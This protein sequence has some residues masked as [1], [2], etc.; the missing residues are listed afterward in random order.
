[1]PVYFLHPDLYVFPHPEMADENGIL[2]IGGDLDPER[3]LTAYRF[4]IFPW[5]DEDDPITW[6]SPDPRAVVIPG[7]VKVS[8]SMRPYLRKY[9]LKID[10]SFEEVISFCKEIQRNDEFG[11]WITGEMMKT[12]IELHHLG[13]AHSFETW[14]DGKLIGGLYGLSLG[15][16]FFGESM[17]SLK[18]N[19]SKFAFIKLSQL[20]KQWEFLLIDCQVPNDHLTSM[21]CT[22]I[23][24]TKYLDFMRQNLRYITKNGRWTK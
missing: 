16:C 10:T 1:M 3:V 17:F 18:S 9:E 12:Y 4:G 11:T 24:R 22:K 23:S 13:Y 2:A 20:L 5:Y 7:E 14:Y 15:K 6:W 8:K 19:A 21:G